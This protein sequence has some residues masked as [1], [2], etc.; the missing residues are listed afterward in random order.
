MLAGRRVT[1]M[2]PD[3]DMPRARRFYEDVLGLAAEGL[4]PDGK[5][6]YECRGALLALCPHAR[7]A[8]RRQL[9][10]GGR[11][12]RG[13]GADPARRAVLARRG[14]ARRGRALL[15]SAS[16]AEEAEK[17]TEHRSSVLSASVTPMLA[18]APWPGSSS[19]PA[20]WE[21]DEDLPEH[22]GLTFPL[23]CNEDRSARMP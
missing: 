4:R 10:G 19:A 17:T 22:Q 3:V 18:P 13:R 12:R 20:R 15:R 16:C 5:F 8:N 21:A 9:R 7:R 6:V 23:G 14:V 1:T 11:L 2:L